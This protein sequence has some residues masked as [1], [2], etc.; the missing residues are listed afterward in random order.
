MQCHCISTGSEQLLKAQVAGFP[1]EELIKWALATPVQFIIG[2]RFHVGA[3]KSL[4][5]GVANMEVLVALGT[6]ASY[7]YSVISIL[8]HHFTRHH[9][10]G[11]YTPTV[12]PAASWQNN[13]NT[14]K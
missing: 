1:C 2:W 7:L 8:H 9:K 14:T 13:C 12:R 5:R 4:K 10:H 6:D 3:W 11:T